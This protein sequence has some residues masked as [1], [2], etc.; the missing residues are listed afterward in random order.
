MATN[1]PFL[2]EVASEKR[3]TFLSTGMTDLVSIEKAVQIFKKHNCELML[4]H[5]VSTYPAEEKDLNLN[6]METLEKKFNL[7]IGYSGHE[8]SVSPSVVAASLG[9]SVIERHITLDRAMYGSD[10]SASLEK[11]GL[12]EL[13]S[14]L[15]KIP[16]L[17]GSGEKVILKE[18]QNVA[19]KLRYWT[20]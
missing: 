19:K 10:Q 13:T 6:C 9:A 2:E 16:N 1:L 5:T 4:F 14:I 12:M 7:P 3:P 18:E 17:L 11:S 20:N 8:A 15:R